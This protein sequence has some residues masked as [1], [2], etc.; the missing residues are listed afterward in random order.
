M[1]SMLLSLS[2]LRKLTIFSLWSGECQMV[3]CQVLH[4]VSSEFQAWD[5]LCN[6][7]RNVVR[8]RR[9]WCCIVYTCSAPC[10]LVV[11]FVKLQ[12][13]GV[14]FW[15]LNGHFSNS[16]KAPFWLGLTFPNFCQVFDSVVSK[17]SKFL[18][19]EHLW[20]ELD[21]ILDGNVG[22]ILFLEH[23]QEPFEYSFLCFRC[24]AES[25]Q[26]MIVPGKFN[27]LIAREFFHNFL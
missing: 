17:G 6:C 27:L 13:L 10:G 22:P 18:S 3:S 11:T 24:F 14:C 26:K 16:S 8:V 4:T 12:L 25:K 1:L 9:L 15:R 20:K 5:I 19:F 7:P 21:C 2:P 23:L